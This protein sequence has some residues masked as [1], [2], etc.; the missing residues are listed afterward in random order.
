M[1][2]QTL[3]VLEVTPKPLLYQGVVP[4]HR[5]TQIVISPSS[6]LRLRSF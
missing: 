6:H 4:G 2:V 3:V 1:Y 5:P